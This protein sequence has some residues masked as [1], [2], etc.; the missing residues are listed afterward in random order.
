MTKLQ[1]YVLFSKRD[2]NENSYM[3][4]KTLHYRKIKGTGT[5]K[6]CYKV[7]LLHYLLPLAVNAFVRKVNKNKQVLS[8]STVATMTPE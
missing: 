2:T 4:I 8:I 6:N 1:I 3:Q 5:T 7:F